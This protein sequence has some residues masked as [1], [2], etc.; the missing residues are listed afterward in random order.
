MFQSLTRDAEADG[1]TQY[2]V[3]AAISNGDKLL[4]LHNIEGNKSQ[5]NFPHGNLESGEQ[6]FEGL[7]RIVFFYLNFSI[8]WF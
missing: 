4:L 7:M 3:S 5:Y 8:L 2:A 1:I 6:L